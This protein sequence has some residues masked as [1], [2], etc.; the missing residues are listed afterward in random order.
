MNL[1]P[2][3]SVEQHIAVMRISVI[4]SRRYSS[5]NQLAVEAGASRCRGTK[6]RMVRLYAAH[7]NEYVTSLIES[8]AE[9][10]LKL[11]QLVAA[12]AK[13]HE[14]VA[15]NINAGR[16]FEFTLEAIQ[17]LNRRHGVKQLRAGEAVKQV[18][19][20]HN[21]LHQ[22]LAERACEG[23]DAG[24][25]KFDFEEAVNNGSRLADQLVQAVFG[26]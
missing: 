3:D 24:V 15:L 13:A 1:R 9:Q 10:E 19:S 7:R 4:I 21:F 23:F 20:A 6:P 8:F 12:C 14:I 17:T 26:H 22:G 5:E 16:A 2:E 18:C 25:R 11:A